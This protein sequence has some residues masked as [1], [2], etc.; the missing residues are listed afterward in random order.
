MHMFVCICAHTCTQAYTDDHLNVLDCSKNVPNMD[1]YI[2]T[3]MY[4]CVNVHD[5][6]IHI[7][8]HNVYVY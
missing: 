2:Y 4:T 1:I 7:H 5:I 3:Y 8:M 6:Y